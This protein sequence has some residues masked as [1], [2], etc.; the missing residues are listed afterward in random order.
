MTSRSRTLNRIMLASFVVAACAAPAAAQGGSQPATP[1]EMV[2]TYNTLADGILA[3]K[4]TETNLVRSI[5]SATHAHAQVQLDRARK[6][7][8]ANDA[9]GAPRRHRGARGRR[10]AAR[11]GRR[12]R[13][14]CRAEAAAAGRPP[15]QCRGRGAG[16]LR[17]GLRH[18]HE[19]GKAAAA[20]IVTRDRGNG[21]R[22]EDAGSRRRVEQGAGGGRRPDEAGEVDGAGMSW[23]SR[24]WRGCIGRRA[25]PHSRLCSRVPR[26]PLRPRRRAR[27]APSSSSTWRPQAGV[28]RVLLAGRPGK[29]HLLDSLGSGAAFLDFDRD[30]RLDIYVVNGWTL[31]GASRRRARQERA[32]PRDARRHVPGR[33]GR[34]RRRRRRAMGPGRRG[35]RR[36]RR[37]LARHLR[38]RLRREHPLSQPGQRPL[39]ERRGRGSGSSRPAGTPAP[40]S[41][42]RTATAISTSTSPPTS[43]RRWRTCSRRSGRSA[44]RASRWS[45]SDPFGMKGA[46]DHF[47]RNDSGTF[48]DATAAAGM[49][50]RALALRPRRARVRLRRRRRRRRVRRQRLGPQLPLSQRGQR[51]VQGGR[52]LV[53]LRARREGRRA[54]EHGRRRRRRDGARPLRHLRHQLRRR[55]LHAHR[56]PGRRP[57][58]R[59]VARRRASGR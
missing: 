3:L 22:R 13:R 49:Q 57:V 8:A 23:R 30:G 20:R 21:P 52:H 44:G 2:A 9:A 14:G 24:D 42:T 54:G 50:D 34:G 35:R 25:G 17:R 19:S 37:R 45:P 31:D 55:L 58:R 15:S 32:L 47:F 46:P 1:S 53:R 4:N 48:V 11:D 27:V 38:H 36:R 41:S 29:D 7:I 18:R 10:G 5:L 28:T 16:H 26:P 59:R 33:D 56:R 12:Q 51:H 43:T 40:P 6:A 39:R